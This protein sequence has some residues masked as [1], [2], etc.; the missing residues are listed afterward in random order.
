LYFDGN[1]KFSPALEAMRNR[2]I[3]MPDDLEAII[4]K[5]QNYEDVDSL[6]WGARSLLDE[7]F[8]LGW[9]A[10]Y[11]YATVYRSMGQS[12]PEFE[13]VSADLIRNWETLS[14][15]DQHRDECQ[16]FMGC[17]LSMLI[18]LESHLGK[19]SAE[20]LYQLV[21]NMIVDVSE[22]DFEK[23][24]L[25]NFMKVEPVVQDRLHL[26]FVHDQ[27]REICDVANSYRAG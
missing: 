10:I 16:K 1:P 5:V 20:R 9:A 8:H 27:V 22:G 2:E 3:P 13:R 21:L 11:L 25:I 6:I 14:A 24:S 12:T 18:Q 4:S 17:Y 19:A 7:N 23:L 15:K 26:H